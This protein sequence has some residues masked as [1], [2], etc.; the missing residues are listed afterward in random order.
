MTDAL[1][2]APHDEAYFSSTVELILRAGYAV[3][4]VMWPPTAD[5]LPEIIVS[6]KYR[7][8]CATL[9]LCGSRTL[10]NFFL[11]SQALRFDARLHRGTVATVSRAQQCGETQLVFSVVRDPWSRVVSCYEKKIR[12]AYAA[13]PYRGIPL[14]ASYRGLSSRMPFDAFVE[15]LCS[16]EGQDDLANRHWMSQH[17]FLPLS[18]IMSGTM[19]VLKLK[20]D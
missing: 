4:R 19:K 17:R 5:C 7:L 14:I 20:F 3:R 9:P 13:H 16:P 15:W 12:G 10:K 6:S 8:I 1:I 18:D 11:S 2:A